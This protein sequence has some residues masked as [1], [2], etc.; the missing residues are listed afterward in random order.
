MQ[1]IPGTL[2]YFRPFFVAQYKNDN[3]SFVVVIICRQKTLQGDL[4]K[5]YSWAKEYNMT[6]N[7]SKFELLRYG[8]NNTLKESTSY[9]SSDGSTAESKAHTKDVG[10]TMSSN[11]TFSEHISN[12]CEKARDICSWIIQTFSSRA[13]LL[14]ITLWKSLVQPILD[15]FSQLW[16]PTQPGHIKELE[17]VQKNFTRKIKLDQ[18]L[19]YWERLND[20]NIFSQER[21][22]ER[23]R[24]IYVWK[25]LENIVPSIFHGE[26]GGISKLHARNGRTIALPVGNTSCPRAIQKM[27]DSSLIVHWAKLFNCLPRSIRNLTNCSVLE[28]KVELDNF[29]SGIPDEPRV[30]GYT[31]YCCSISNSLLHQVSK[32]SQSATYKLVVFSN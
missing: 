4:E 19:N 7:N 6:F 9:D 25:M 11:G 5:I 1:I 13:P 3:K 22:R 26:N 15:Y 16:C 30:T 29:V 17:E 31:Q 18:R 21:R 27:R 2:K 23:Y 14:M 32:R 10:V 12:T 24:I 28:F 20:L 8:S